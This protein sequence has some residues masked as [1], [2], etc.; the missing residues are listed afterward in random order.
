MNGQ[1][2]FAF[3]STDNVCGDPRLLFSFCCYVVS[4]VKTTNLQAILFSPILSEKFV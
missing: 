1:F 2:G 3:V 4:V